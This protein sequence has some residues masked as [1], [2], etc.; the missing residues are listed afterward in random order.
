MGSMLTTRQ[1]GTGVG[2]EVIGDGCRG[3]PLSTPGL[4]LCL[5][6][7][8]LHWASLLQRKGASLVTPAHP[9]G[10]PTLPRLHQI[11]AE[12]KQIKPSRSRVVKL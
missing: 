4:Y 5:C 10:P 1:E 7:T 2:G 12:G 3:G 8:V 9:A 6:Q 11:R